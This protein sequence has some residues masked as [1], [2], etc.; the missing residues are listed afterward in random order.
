MPDSTLPAA[1]GV[2]QEPVSGMRLHNP[3][4]A[5]WYISVPEARLRGSWLSALTSLRCMF[6]FSFWSKITSK[7]LTW[8]SASAIRRVRSLSSSRLLDG[9]PLLCS[10][11]RSFLMDSSRALRVCF[12]VSILSSISSSVFRR[13]NSSLACL[14]C[15]AWS[16][17]KFSSVSSMVKCSAPRLPLSC[18]RRW[19]RSLWVRSSSWRAWMVNCRCYSEKDGV[20]E[21]KGGKSINGPWASSLPL[22]HHD[23]GMLIMR[24][25]GQLWSPP[26]WLQKH[27]TAHEEG[28]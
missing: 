6:S 26:R 3:E 13:R 18:C 27:G 10:I 2:D 5:D 25:R 9:N 11:S 15:S 20:G 19:L 8:D 7:W 21:E 16:L 4:I 14:S 24:S 28:N 1:G 23:D 12:C 22:P 17:R